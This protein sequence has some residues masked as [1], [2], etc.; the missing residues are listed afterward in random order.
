MEKCCVNKENVD[1]VLNQ[2]VNDDDTVDMSEIFKLLGDP[3]RLR[4]VSALRI[5]ELCVG[6]LSEIMEIS[7]SGVS[8]QL[9]L[10]KKNRIV[11]SRREGKLIF[12]SLDDKHI[13]QLLDI[14][15]DHVN[16]VPI[17]E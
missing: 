5:S 13:E 3:S 4:I 8:H 14:C 11:K 10:L 2:I 1:L 12:Y 7:Q 15:L 6:D 17:K 9:R 16:H